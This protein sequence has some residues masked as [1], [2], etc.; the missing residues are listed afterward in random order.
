[1]TTQA[2]SIIRKIALA[3][4][5]ILLASASVAGAGKKKNIKITRE[6]W[7]EHT[8]G[9][10]ILV[11]FTFKWCHHCKNFKPTWNALKK[12]YASDE[13]AFLD[14][15][16]DDTEG[17]YL[18]DDFGVGGVP[19]LRWGN[20]AVTFKYTGEFE[21]EAIEDLIR[22]E[23]V[24]AKLCSILEPENCPEEDRADMIAIEKLTSEYLEKIHGLSNVHP[25]GMA[26]QTVI[27]HAIE[28]PF[29][30]DASGVHQRYGNQPEEELFTSN[31]ES[32]KAQVQR[33]IDAEN[34]VY[35]DDPDTWK[36][37]A[38]L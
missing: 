12:K 11:L 15:D 8:L 37:D 25:I 23:V 26:Q 14:V 32:I 3:V 13:L 31:R 20:T 33:M 4:I 27:K 16:C 10:K 34:R 30:D 9:K 29:W 19:H 36:P 1:M 5:T 38:E 24:P 7:P 21:E 22:D 28:N 17:D 35:E 2:S 6:N 18:C